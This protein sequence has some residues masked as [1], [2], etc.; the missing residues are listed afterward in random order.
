MELTDLA[1]DV[2]GATDYLLRL[3]AAPPVMTSRLAL[4]ESGATRRA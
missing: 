4:T 2:M 1:V 3:L